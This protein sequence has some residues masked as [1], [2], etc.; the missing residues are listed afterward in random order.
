MSIIYTSSTI[1]SIEI[2]KTKTREYIQKH[3]EI[4][5][6]I[7]WTKYTLLWWSKD[8][9]EAIYESSEQYF[10]QLWLRQSIYV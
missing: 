1:V 2:A 5:W 7:Y 10:D 9:V 4:Y 8:E 3:Y 6:K